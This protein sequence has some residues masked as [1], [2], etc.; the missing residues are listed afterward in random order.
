[1]DMLREAVEGRDAILAAMQEGIVLFDDDGHVRYV[2]AAASELLGR[3]FS[4]VGDIAPAALSQAVRRAQ[5]GE[6]GTDAEFEVGGRTIEA[7]ATEAQPAGWVLLVARDVTAARQTEQLRRNFVANASHELKTPVSSI[8]GLA[9][10]LDLAEGDP[11]A[12]RRFIAML[13]REAERLSRLVSDLLDLSRLESDAGPLELV[14]LDQVMIDQAEKVRPTAHAAGLR[15]TV[16][17]PREIRVMGRESDLAQMVHNLLANAVRYTHAGGEVLLNLRT[18]GGN[19][20]VQVEDTGIGIPAE[21]IDRVFERFYRVDP[22]RDRETGGTGLGLAIVRHVAE[23]HGGRVAVS[24][25]LGVGSSFTVHIPL[26]TDR[27]SSVHLDAGGSLAVPG[28]A[29]VGTC[30]TR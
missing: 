25:T 3:R 28:Q 5:V 8:L 20:V 19:A 29:A 16:R 18:E 7:V 27:A 10:A 24:S 9:S 23:S 13:G 26:Q 1:M 17:R 14:R 21:D 6:G 15:F 12:T 30:L 11:A 22:A 4:T 2:N